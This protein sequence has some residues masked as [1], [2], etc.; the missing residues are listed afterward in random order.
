MNI[1]QPVTLLRYF[2]TYVLTLK[3][4]KKGKERLG[5]VSVWRYNLKIEIELSYYHLDG[6]V[7]RFIYF[8]SLAF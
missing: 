8:N 7:G 4:I 1:V 5:S 6:L 2:S 3:K